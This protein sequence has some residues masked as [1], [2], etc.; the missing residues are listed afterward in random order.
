MSEKKKAE[1][2][3]E[4]PRTTGHRRFITLQA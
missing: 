3:T 4:T 2:K 1:T